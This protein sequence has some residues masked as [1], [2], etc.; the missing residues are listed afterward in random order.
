MIDFRYHLVSIV[1]VFLA[2]ATGLLLGSTSAVQDV[3]QKVADKSLD[4]IQKTNEELRDQVTAQEDQ[5]QGQD[6]FAQVTGP[7]ILADRLKDTSV[8]FVLAPGAAEQTRTGLDAA[9]KSAGGT[10]SGWVSLADPYLADG[11]AEVI[12]QLA[13]QLKPSGLTYG[14]NA[15][16]YGKAA[17]LLAHVLVTKDPE[18]AGHEDVASGAVLAAFKEAGLLTTSGKPEARAELALLVAPGTPY[19]GDGAEADDNALVALAGALDS[20][21]QGAVAAG[22]TASAGSGGLLSVLRSSET[23]ERVSSVDTADTTFGQIVS[24]LALNVEM[25]GESGEYGTGSG[26]GG[27]LP[28]PLPPVPAKTGARP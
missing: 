7:T 11:Q 20:A 8:V 17:A 3:S 27:Y 24:V 1:A 19:T 15:D 9:V 10:V 26:V 14:E 16:A 22:N 18:K 6:Q 4:Y 5:L 12:D 28:D 13:E 21:G 2:L 25:N 23:G